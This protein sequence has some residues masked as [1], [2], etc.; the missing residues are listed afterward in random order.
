MG[1][2]VG[3]GGGDG[4]DATGAG[5]TGLPEFASASGPTTPI[6]FVGDWAR[7]FDPPLLRSRPNP[8][9][10]FNATTT[11]ITATITRVLF[12]FGAAGAATGGSCRTGRGRGLGGAGGIGRTVAGETAGAW[13]FTSCGFRGEAS[14]GGSL[15]PSGARTMNDAW[16]T[17]QS[18]LCPIS[19]ALRILIFVSHLGQCTQKRIGSFSGLP[20]ERSEFGR[21]SLLMHGLATAGRRGHLQ[22]RTWPLCLSSLAKPIRVASNL[23]NWAAMSWP[24]SSRDQAVPPRWR[25]DNIP[26]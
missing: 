21:R 1:A 20:G 4:M 8:R 10:R 25:I 23:R 11:A 16:Q 13:G 5:E 6:S 24:W 3:V 26:W 15:K 19:L 2:G 9:A 17:G 22:P 14:V 7:F 12:D 18:T